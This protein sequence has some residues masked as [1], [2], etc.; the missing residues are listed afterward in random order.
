M[1]DRFVVK[2][3]VNIFLIFIVMLVSTSAICLFHDLWID[4]LLGMLIITVIFFTLF[5]FI[6]EHNRSKRLIAGNRESDYHRVLIGYIISSAMCIISSFMPEFLKPVMLIPILMIAYGSRAVALGT[7][8]F[9][10]SILCLVLSA[11]VQELV[12]YCLMTLFGCILAEAMD[13]SK[14]RIWCEIIIFCLCVSLPPLFHYITYQEIDQSLLLY[15]ALEGVLICGLLFLSYGKLMA[16]RYQEVP[17]LLDDLIADDYPMVRELAEFSK[18]EYNHAR[19]VSSMAKKCASV[20]AAD[21]KVCAAAGFYY[22]I[23]II[24]GELIVRN[25]IKIAQQYCF[26]EP[27]IRIISEYNGEEALPSTVES[28]IV[29]MVDALIKKLEVLDKQKSMASEWNRDMLIYQTLNE[30]SA[31]GLYDKSGLSMNMY[32]KIREFLVKEEAL[33]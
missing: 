32:L 7:G 26:P 33:L 2:R 16:L 14:M 18:A 27:V 21:E 6:L 29:H 31:D 12:L 8:I 5:L 15:G 25:G 24:D 20:V 17:E 11:S 23:G 3:A 13:N 9:L 30:F 4:E 28:A 19:R 1:K 22:R 10:N